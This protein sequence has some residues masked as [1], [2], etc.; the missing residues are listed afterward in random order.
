MPASIAIAA[1]GDVLVADA[2]NHRID[3][4]PPPG[5]SLGHWGRAGTVPG[6]FVDPVAITVDRAGRLLVADAGSGRVQL[7]SGG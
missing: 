4:F 3:V 6:A 5:T 1:N 7:F 2:G